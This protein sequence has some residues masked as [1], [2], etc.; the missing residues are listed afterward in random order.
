[1][2]ETINILHQRHE[3]LFVP[4][5]VKN[6]LREESS[7]TKSSFMELF[8]CRGIFDPMD[9]NTVKSERFF[10]DATYRRTFLDKYRRELPIFK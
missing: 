7:S 3:D 9:G 10:V 5:N 1:M 4:I 8:N 6:N 2:N